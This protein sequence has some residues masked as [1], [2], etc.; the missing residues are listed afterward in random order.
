MQR[1]AQL[2]VVE[3]DAELAEMIRDCLSDSMSADVTVAPDATSALREELTTRHDV[4]VLS[5][6][7]GDADWFDLA[8]EL[9]LTNRGPI[10]LLSESPTM[11]DMLAAVRMGVMDVML[12]PFDL[13]DM[14]LLMKRAVHRA[15][16]RQRTRVRYRRLRRLTARIICERRDLRERIDLICRDFVHAYRRLAQRVSETELLPHK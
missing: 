2:L 8:R 4:L 16:A 6:E 7:L 13:A 12:K 5:T 1:T 10:V 11:D 15:R 14:S 3:P 9:R